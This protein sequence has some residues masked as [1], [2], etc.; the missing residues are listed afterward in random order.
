M[1]GDVT[2]SAR[3]AGATGLVGV[4]SWSSDPERPPWLP[5]SPSF[6]PSTRRR[7][8]PRSC[9]RCSTTSTP[10]CWW[11]T[12][13]P[14]DDTVGRAVRG[15]R[16]R[17]EPSRS[18]WGSAPRCAPGSASPTSAGYPVA[19]Q[20]DADGQHEVADAKR[21]VEAVTDGGADLVVGSRFSAGYDVSRLRRLS[22]RVLSRRVSRYVGR[23]HHRHHQRVPGLQR[24]GPSSASP[25]PIRPPT[26]PTRSRR[27]CWPATS[28]FDRGRDERADAR[29]PGRPA[30]VATRCGIT[31]HFVRLW[32]VLGLH[33]FRRPTA[34]GRGAGG[35]PA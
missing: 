20:I 6:R 3:L 12:T 8:S 24:P 1:Q 11:S 14:S 10:T 17:V 13:D 4:G 27:C 19:V 30:V 31:Y 18:T 28:G 25:A 5:Y 16:H 23:A 32:L 2:A 33:R 7:P 21:L 9:A 35:G 29:P 26:C 15:R 34:P 22:M